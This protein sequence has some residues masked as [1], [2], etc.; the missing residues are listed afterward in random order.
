M[1][2][3]F[4]GP[5]TYFRGEGE[6]ARERPPTFGGVGM[7]KRFSLLVWMIYGCE[8]F[9]SIVEWLVWARARSLNF[10]FVSC[11]I[12]VDLDCARAGRI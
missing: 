11:H 8:A 4:A 3:I 7:R 10:F 12:L 6:R 1:I 5:H 9:F 2:G